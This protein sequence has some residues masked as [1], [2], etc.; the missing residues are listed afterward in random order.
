MSKYLYGASVQGIQ[1]FIFKTNKLKEIIGASKIVESIDGVNKTYDI[2][3]DMNDGEVIKKTFDKYAKSFQEEYKLE[4]KPEVVLLVAG[5]MV[6]IFENEHDLEKLVLEMPKKVMQKAYGI[7]FSQA[8]V[9]Y[10]DNNY[11]NARAKLE[12]K[13][14]IQRNKPAI[15]LDMNFSILKQNPLTARPLEDEYDIGTRQKVKAFENYAN[16]N[17]KNEKFDIHQIANSKNK[18][19][20]IHADGNGLGNIVKDLTKDTIKGFSLRL[21]SATKKAFNKAVNEI[22]E[23]KYRK[24]VLDGDDLTLVCDAS[25]A[26]EF[27]QSFLSEFERLTKEN[28][29]NLTVCA[30]IAFCNEKYPMHYALNL[31]EDLCSEAKKH[32]KK[33]FEKEKVPPSCLMFHNIQSSAVKDFDKFI[34]DELT[35]KD[36]RLDFAPYYLSAKGQPKIQDFLE[37]VKEFQKENS[38][39]GKL[40]EWLNDLEYDENYAKNQ[41]ERIEEILFSS[42]NKIQ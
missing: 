31:A 24:I 34:E 19:A 14:K 11:K 35:I 16:K 42:K 28:G 32:T 22:K 8:V 1:D 21:D 41:L 4:Y 20:V 6:L 13:L 23:D 9:K 12:E 30:G 40:R 29:D 17:Y 36:K 10:E 37:T 5:S 38:P 26:L 15:P 25:Y 3:A 7:T 2:E 18:I 27:T 33:I 39:K